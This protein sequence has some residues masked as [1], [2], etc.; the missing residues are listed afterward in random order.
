MIQS[1]PAIFN[2]AA[3]ND[4]AISFTGIVKRMPG[5]LGLPLGHARNDQRPAREKERT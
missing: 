1:A 4:A 3:A 5:P 2:G